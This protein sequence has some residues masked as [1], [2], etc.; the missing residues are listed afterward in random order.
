MSVSKQ[1]LIEKFL[2][3]VVKESKGYGWYVE[4]YVLDF[5]SESMVRQRLRVNR[6]VKRYRT[7]R[8]KQLAAQAVA[9]EVNS[10]LS[11]G[12]SPI[13]ETEDARLYT[14]IPAMRDKFLLHKEAEGIRPA[15]MQSYTCV[16]GMFVRWCEDAGRLN[17]FSGTFLR[18]D[19]V[20]YL[21]WLKENG[22]SNRNYN[23]HL[24]VMRCLWNWA[25]EHCYCKENA[26]ALVKPLRN[27][28]KRRVLIDTESRRR[29]AEW[30]QENCPQYLIVV[31]LVY[32]SAMRPKEIA[33]IQIKHID[34]E[35]H[36]VVVPGEVAKNGK[37][38]CATLSP[39]LVELLRDVVGGC[40]G[41]WY[42]FGSR[43]GLLPCSEMV[44]MSRF[45]KKWDDLRADLCLP[46]EMQL[47][48]LRDTGITDL[49]HAGIDQL[50]VQH[51][52]DHS[53]LAVQAIYTDHFDPNVNNLNSAT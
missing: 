6:L 44:S 3:A 48:S 41:E 52:V 32:S 25:M 46:K 30:C 33:N 27:E 43:A 47:Y 53:S 12:W 1:P 26:F 17:L 39:R 9:D 22:S 2:P 13:H 28:K 15:T 10:K 14:K 37:Q 35:R 40:P 51:H 8:E 34:L 7:K 23:N 20:A 16:T 50:T 42:L 4:Y 21:D 11:R 29:I 45:R 36:C 24:K 5:A 19:A 38:R 49:L 31:M 18:S